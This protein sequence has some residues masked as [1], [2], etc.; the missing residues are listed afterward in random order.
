MESYTINDFENFLKQNGMKN[1]KKT[2]DK[3]TQIMEHGTLQ[4]EIDYEKL[5]SINEL[6]SIY[7]IG[8]KKAKQ[9]W[10]VN[11]KN[12]EETAINPPYTIFLIEPSFN[13][14][15]KMMKQNKP[16]AKINIA[17]R[18]EVTTTIYADNKNIID[19]NKTMIS[20]RL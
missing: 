6:T 3:I 15:E 7:G 11:I 16:N 13:F 20:F 8:M 4:Q 19:A 14:L 5:N 10:K 2:L 17:D 1:P 18:E 12:S 9:L